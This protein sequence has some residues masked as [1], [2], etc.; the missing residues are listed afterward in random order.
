[1]NRHSRSGASQRRSSRRGLGQLAAWLAL[2]PVLLF[3]I[4]PA[5]AFSF[6][7]KAKAEESSSNNEAGRRAE[8]AFDDA[9][10]KIKAGDY[11]GSIPL[12]QQSLAA[13]PNNADALSELGH[14]LRKVGR[15]DESLQSYQKALALNP[16][17]LNAA[18]YLGE[19]YLDMKRPDLARE[20]LE[21]LAALCPSGCE[22]RSELQ[23]RIAAYRPQ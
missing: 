10:A 2:V 7:K 6:G 3:L 5:H 9:L 14:S 11:L 18:E 13:N 8:S 4:A 22:P 15:L 20:E 16:K 17:H 19:L 23:E 12:L 21:V 1:M